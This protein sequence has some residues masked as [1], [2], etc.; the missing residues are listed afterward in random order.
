MKSV[1]SYFEFKNEISLQSAPSLKQ[2]SKVRPMNDTHHT[3][4]YTI[5][6]HIQIM[7]SDSKCISLTKQTAK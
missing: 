6:T 5:H 7:N 3:Q 4:T 2:F 1:Y